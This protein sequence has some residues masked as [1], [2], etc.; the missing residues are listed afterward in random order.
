MKKSILFATIAIVT[1]FGCK[2]DEPTATC[3]FENST[4]IGKWKLSKVEINGKDSTNS[5]FIQEPCQKSLT[6]EFKSSGIISETNSS[7]CS[8]EKDRNW[9]LVTQTNKNYLIGYDAN[10][11]DTVEIIDFSCKTFSTNPNG[12]IKYTAT[13]Q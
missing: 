1:F 6:I 7:G 2:K 13:K 11:Q 4:F 10:D 3:K 5:F 12:N 8:T 9:K